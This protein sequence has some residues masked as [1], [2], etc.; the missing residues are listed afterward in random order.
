MYKTRR[1]RN[2]FSAGQERR[3]TTSAASPYKPA[4]AWY[5]H[6]DGAELVFLAT[7]LNTLTIR[8]ARHS[9]ESF[10]Q[11]N[12]AVGLPGMLHLYRLL[13][14]Q[15]QPGPS[16]PFGRRRT[17]SMKALL[18]LLSVSANA[19]KRWHIVRTARPAVLAAF[20]LGLLL[21]GWTAVAQDACQNPS[22]SSVTAA[23]L[24]QGN[25][26]EWLRIWVFTDAPVVGADVGVSVRGSEDRPEAEFKA[27]TNDQGVFP[28]YVHSH[29]YFRVT[30]SGGTIG[31]GAF[32]G[33]LSAD[34]ALTDPAHQFVVVNPVTTLVSL[35]LDA[36]PELRLDGAEARVRRFLELPDNYSL[37][38]AL[39][40]SSLYASP[41]FS[42]ALFMREAQAA[43]G[44]GAFEQQL[45]QELLA[46]PSAKHPF[47]PPPP[48]QL[49]AA[50]TSSPESIMSAGLYAGA[51]DF[52]SAE[53][54]SNL[55]GW[56]M[57]LTGIVP[58]STTTDDD[59]MALT[60]AL[61]SLQNSIIAL[62]TEVGELSALVKS[63]ATQEEY[64]AIVN[65]AEPIATRVCSVAGDISYFA[66]ECPPLPVDLPPGYVNPNQEWCDT[67]QP[68]YLNELQMSYENKDYENLETYIS[69][70]GTTEG[71]LHLYSLWL[72]ESKP[73]FRPAD[74]T[75]MQNLYDYWNGVLTAAANLRMEFFH[76]QN[77][78]KSPAGQGQIIAFIGNPAADPPTT[79]NFQ[80]AQT[81]NLNLMFP[82]VPETTVIDTRSQLMWA[83]G[84]PMDFAYPPSIPPTCPSDFLPPTNLPGYGFEGGPNF[85]MSFAGLPGWTSPTQPEMSGLVNG[86]NS[87]TG[88]TSA[89][90][91]LISQS[92]AV[93]PP[94]SPASDGF[95]N[96]LACSN[97]YTNVWTT[98]NIGSNAGYISPYA[99][100]DIRDG[101]VLQKNS[102][103]AEGFNW[104]MIT[105]PLA[106]GEQYFWY[107]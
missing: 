101:N 30:I 9:W 55:F 23:T 79:G 68:I 48:Q 104:Q 92:D 26:H 95:F 4:I 90:S 74:S 54:V 85:G 84:F 44:L 98:T 89:M 17:M 73:F 63:T 5:E 72:G 37:G 97:V 15:E 58:T 10:V 47:P 39:R 107:Q 18:T 59:I 14:R 69:D 62:Q 60:N 49:A 102:S 24:A 8:R 13:V 27:A 88:A 20:S 71:I 25:G 3:R 43:G 52:T 66:Q 65:D 96:I 87:G 100:V 78:Q 35:V 2:G 67:W 75:K 50:S 61:A 38:L 12:S 80:A 41:F 81:T 33:W 70:S 91:W 28:A 16:W 56:A 1:S 93:S 46:S 76:Q 57:S 29:H 22:S 53:G 94:D 19:G 106:H 51:L 45:L 6:S 21:T 77:D 82:A 103:A 86:W 99:L 32:S 11:G 42:S 64:D 31:G 83:T 7:E 36:R 40:Q 34:V 105:R